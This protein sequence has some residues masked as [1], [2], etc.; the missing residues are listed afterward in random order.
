MI[1]SYALCMG[2]QGGAPRRDV[3]RNPNV[4]CATPLVLPEYPSIP[5]ASPISL[6]WGL[7]FLKCST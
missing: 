1:L 2:E 7:P 6:L 4:P 5:I 3:T